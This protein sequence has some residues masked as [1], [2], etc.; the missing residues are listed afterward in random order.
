MQISDLIKQSNPLNQTQQQQMN[1]LLGSLDTVQRA[2]VHGY[3]AATLSVTSELNAVPAAAS[4][5]PQVTVLYGSQTGNSRHLAEQLAE[6]CNSLAVQTRVLDMADYKNRDLKKE[7]HLILVTSTYGEGE[8]PE[9]AIS[10]YNFLY[11]KKAPSLKSL[12]FAVLGLGDSSYEFFCKTALDFH[13]QLEQLGAQSLLPCVELDV[14]YETAAE[15]W[16]ERVSQLLQERCVDVVKGNH[17]PA[18]VTPTPLTTYNKKNPYSAELYTHQRITGRRSSKDI[19]HVELALGD[20]GL[21]YQPGDS[22]GVYFKN[23]QELVEELLELTAVKP[24]AEVTLDGKT[25]SI[26]DAIKEHK[27]ITQA[28]PGFVEFYARQGG[29]EQLNSLLEDKKQLHSYLQSR[30]IIDIVREH[31]FPLPAQAL[32]D[33]LR[34]LQPRLYSIASSQKEVEDEVHLTVAVVRYEA[35]GVSHTGGASGFLADR[36]TA[37]DQVRIYVEENKNFRLPEEDDSDVIMIGPGTGIA[38]FRA[39]LQE[40]EQRK[41]KGKNWLFFGNPHFTEDFLYQVEWQGYLKNGLLTRIDLAFSRD[42]EDKLYVQHR[43]REQGKEVYAWLQRGAYLYICGDGQRM[44][45]DV[46]A[47]L[48][49]IVQQYG[50]KTDTEAS[51]YLQQLKQQK[52]YQKDVY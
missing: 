8:P 17:P 41:A 3:I 16:E 22:L 29:I 14:D 31:P 23:D 20:S 43:L 25:L 40:R 7:S 32:V 46:E 24:D 5:E 52:R 33:G 50:N 47:E 10:L 27:E 2:W 35:F 39:F 19:R 42:Q 36:I 51:D 13:A 15:E 37:G 21:T 28:Y 44:A 49:S 18:V 30:Q 4:E 1:A 11:S 38:P 9:N 26:V 34:K 48:I 6:R 12:N 45:K